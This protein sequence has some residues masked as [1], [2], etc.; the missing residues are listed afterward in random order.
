MQRPLEICPGLGIVIVTNTDSGR[1]ARGGVECA[2][3]LRQILETTF[4]KYMC[5]YNYKM[6]I[7]LYVYF[8]NYLPELFA[9]M[10]FLPLSVKPFLVKVLEGVLVN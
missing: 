9:D 8:Q 2:K 6:F 3:I 1:P 5:C 7:I 4:K 10:T